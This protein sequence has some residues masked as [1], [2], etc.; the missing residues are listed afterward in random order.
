MSTPLFFPSV[1]VLGPGLLGGSLALAVREYL[2]G[3]DIRLWARRQATLDEAAAMGITTHLST[4]L[5]TIVRGASL[6]VLATPIGAFLDLA[7]RALP[8]LAPGCIITDVGSVKAYVHRTTG[9]FLHGHGQ[10]F[11]GS[12][13]MAGSEKQ[14]IGAARA[15]LFQ[16]ASIVLTNDHGAPEAAVNRL[17]SFWEALGGCC[18]QMPSCPHDRTVARISHMPHVLAALAAHNAATGDV[19]AADLHKL[20]STGFR[21]TTRVCSGPP[22]MWADILWENDVAIREILTRCSEDLQHLIHLLE[23]QD[24]PAVARWLAEAKE[25]R[26]TILAHR[27][28]DPAGPCSIPAPREENMVP[29]TAQNPR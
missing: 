9:A 23:I 1:A 14:G 18:H 15:D 10:V 17:A 13:P 26:E 28:P 21:D 24:K 8:H 25:A 19:A 27:S 11:I 16:R 5:A 29:P 2:P 20:A 3:T 6:V 22:A 12:H 4:D 7:E